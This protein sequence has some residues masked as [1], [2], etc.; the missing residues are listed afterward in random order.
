[1]FSSRVF[2]PLGNVAALDLSLCGSGSDVIV[3]SVGSRLAGAAL[4]HLP[5]PDT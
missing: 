4:E 5:L 2:P 1:M 3:L